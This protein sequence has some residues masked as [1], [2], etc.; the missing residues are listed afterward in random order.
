M[1]SAAMAQTVMQSIGE[2]LTQPSSRKA[3]AGLQVRRNS[4]AFA[5]M[6]PHTDAAVGA[7]VGYMQVNNQPLVDCWPCPY[8]CARAASINAL[9]QR[10]TWQY[11]QGSR[12]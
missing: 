4:A 11:E 6:H 5:L 2:A 1:A 3:K 7:S 10:E 9:L 8:I 12:K